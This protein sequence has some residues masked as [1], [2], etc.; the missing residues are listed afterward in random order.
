MLTLQGPVRECRRGV[1]RRDVLRV[2]ALGLGSL[3]LPHVLLLQ[4]DAAT[5]GKATRARRGKSVIWIWL[6]GGASHI[7]SWD[8]KPAAPAEVRGEFKPIP[9]N[10]PGIEICEHLPRQ[11]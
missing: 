4:A 6:R 3:T 1:T 7:D 5:S 10:V 8:M 11:A 9:T 2:G